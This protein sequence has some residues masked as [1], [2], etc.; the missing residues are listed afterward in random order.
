MKTSYKNIYMLAL[1]IL[2]I[3]CSEDFTDLAPTSQR[4]VEN[5]YKTATDMEVAVN[6]IYNALQLDGTYNQSYW[7]MHEMR[8]DNTDQ[9]PGSTGLAR[10]RA[11]IEDFGEISTSDIIEAAWTDSYSG[12]AR[13]NV[14]LNRINSVEMDQGLKDRLTGEALFLRSLFYYHMAISFGNIPLVVTETQSVNEGQDH[15]Q[16]SADVI[17]GQLVTDLTEAENLLN[18]PIETMGNNLGRATKGAAAILLAKVHLLLNEKAAA[19]TVL[20]RIMSDYGY[21]LVPDYND[22]WGENNEHNAESIFEVEFQGGGFGGGNS[23]TND[24][25][26]LPTLPTSVGA[27]RNRPTRE[28]MNTYETGDSRFF[29][30]M[31]TSFVDNEGMLQTNTNNDIRFIVKYG[32]DNPL[33]AEGEGDAPNNFVVFRYAD[34]LLMLAE[35]IGESPEAYDLIN[36]VRDRADLGIIDAATPGTF[37]EKLL[38]ERRVEL[39]FEN[40]RWADLLRF[41]AA[42]S[43]LVAIGK[44]PRLLFLIP[45]KEL[46]LNKN[47]KQN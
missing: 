28:M 27:Y 8:S 23:F 34:V 26:P 11:I 3:S 10:E 36:E 32:I 21:S 16:V 40:H 12:I 9:G 41:G 6:G 14:V 37:E 38:H 4:N 25:S 42:E 13:A 35:A 30:S 46:D 31:D 39:A 24:F 15:V 45:Q 33:G 18:L 1:S 47:F 29:A 17:Y 20:R 7:I 22:L 43:T 2:T 44:S 19:A 5:F